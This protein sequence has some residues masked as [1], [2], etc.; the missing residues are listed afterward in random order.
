[1]GNSHKWEV[2][3][4]IYIPAL[5]PPVKVSYQLATK[6]NRIPAD[7][8]QFDWDVTWNVLHLITAWLKIPAGS[9]IGL[10]KQAG[11]VSSI[12][13]VPGRDG[14]ICESWGC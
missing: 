14:S 9:T 7:D 13:Q 11:I 2:S 5:D 6:R 3:S 12:M 8:A 4:A 10:I 1:M